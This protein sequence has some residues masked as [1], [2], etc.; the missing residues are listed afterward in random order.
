MPLRQ[1]VPRTGSPDA[2]TAEL[3]ATASIAAQP[4]PKWSEDELKALVEFVIASGR[5]VWPTYE[6][7]S[8]WSD[9]GRFS[10]EFQLIT[11]QFRRYILLTTKPTFVWSSMEMTSFF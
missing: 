11:V 5:T 4:L 2:A 3:T 9:A 7:Q 1:L 8:V 10:E 6:R